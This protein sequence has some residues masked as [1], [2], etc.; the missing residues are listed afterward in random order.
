MFAV[1]PWTV[2]DLTDHVE[3]KLPTGLG[4]DTRGEAAI[5]SFGGS[6]KAGCQFD[7]DLTGPTLARYP[8][9]GS[10]VVPRWQ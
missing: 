5:R 3:W 4:S 9:D 6:F 1:N 8:K 10:A 2:C 7:I